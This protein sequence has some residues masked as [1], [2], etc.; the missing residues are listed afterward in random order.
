MGLPDHE[1]NTLWEDDH[2]AHLPFHA[3]GEVLALP[4][5]PEEAARQSTKTAHAN[6]VNI[7]ANCSYEVRC[8][9]P[10]HSAVCMDPKGY[11]PSEC[12]AQQTSTSNHPAKW[13]P[14]HVF[15]T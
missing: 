6:M 12:L 11:S 3:P 9:A 7:H 8:T 10:L 2:L 14:L 15:K 4:E 5:L 1:F 13:P